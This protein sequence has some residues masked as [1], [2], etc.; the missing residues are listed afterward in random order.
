MSQRVARE[1]GNEEV[2][3]DAVKAVLSA[4]MQL[5]TEGE[6]VTLPGFG[7]FKPVERKPRWGRNPTTGEAIFTEAKVVPKFTAGKAF[8]DSVMKANVDGKGKEEGS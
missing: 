1:L 3:N 7:T 4:I 6:S 5:V 8:K 2:A